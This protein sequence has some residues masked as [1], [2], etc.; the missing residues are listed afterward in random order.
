MRAAL[1]SFAR[2]VPVEVVR[3]LIRQGE[4]AR[5]GGRT[6]RLTVLFSDIAGFTTISERMSP[7][8]LTAHMGRYFDALLPIVGAHGGTVDKLIGDAIMAF[9]GA[10]VEDPAH[11]RHALEAVLACRAKLG[12]LHEE[13]ARAG[14]P[15]LP[16]R[17]GLHTGEVV[18]GNVGSHERLS[19][20][21][22]GDTVNLA[23]RLEG[24]GKG[25]GVWV[26]ASADFKAE[27]GEGFVW[28]LVDRVSVKGREAAV[29]VYEPLGR[30]GEVGEAAFAFKQAYEAAFARYEAR[31]FAGAL[32]ALGAQAE[33]EAAVRLYARCEALRDAPPAPD[34][35]PVH[36]LLEK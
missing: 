35:T 15:L 27:V 33:D 3:E 17:F 12:A 14:L 36:R 31:D 22:L 21:V 1:V 8:E 25:Y 6:A 16:T 7:P 9:F 32:E 18:V 5:L 34:W 23:S 13:W 11:A 4:V 30:E 28:R 10:P 20:T 29:E 19:Y 26:L 24:A 2:Y